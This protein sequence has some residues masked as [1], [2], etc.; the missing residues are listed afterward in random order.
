M[1]QN[2]LSLLLV[3]FSIGAMAQTQ[4]LRGT[5]TDAIS[6]Q[7]LP[8][9]VVVVLSHDPVKSTATDD[10]GRFTIPDISI[11]RHHIRITMMGYEEVDLSNVLVTSGKEVVLQITMQESI[12][13]ASEVTV[14]AQKDKSQAVN[15]MAGVSTRSF[16]V[17]ETQKFAAAVN[18][19][20]RM[21]MSFAGV[22]GG[23]DGNNLISIRGN[24]PNG[25]LWRMQ[26]VDIPNPNHFAS[27]ASSGGGISIISAQLLDNSDF[28]TG[29]FSA[30]YGNALSGV[31]DLKLRHGNNQKRE[32]TL[33]AGFLGLDAAIEGPMAKGG[34]YLVNYRYSTLNLLGKMGVPIGDELTNFQ[35]LSYVIFLPTKG[36]S[37]FEWYGFSGW[38][39]SLSQPEMDSSLWVADWNR[40]D[41]Q[42]KSNTSAHG[43]KHVLAINAKAY[44]QTTLQFSQTLNG[45]KQSRLNDD[46]RL[47]HNYTDSDRNNRINLSSVLN[48]KWN[49]KH[50]GRFGVYANSYAFRFKQ[51]HLDTL[52]QVLK[53]SLDAHGQTYTIQAFAQMKYRINKSFSLLYG[54]HALALTLNKTYSLEPRLALQAKCNDRTTYSLGYGM[55]SQMQP[56]GMYFAKDQNSKEQPNRNLDFSRAHHLVVGMDRLL[57]PYLHLKLETY[58]QHLFDVPVAIDP[59]NPLAAFNVVEN[60]ITE[61]MKNDGIGRNYGVELTFEQYTRNN[62]YF[63]LSASLYDSRYKANDG[64]WRNTRFNAN[65]SATFTAGKE[66]N[67]NKNSKRRVIGLNLRVLYNDGMRTTP[68]DYEAS[69]Q[70]GTTVYKEE[71]LYTTK[72][73]EYFRMDLRL[74]VRRDYH[75]VTTTLALDIQNATNHRN[76]QGEYYDPTANQVLTAYQVPFIPVLSY[77]IQF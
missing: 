35:D 53:Q 4:V 24:A 50:S 74:S 30:E 72:V 59:K 41:S 20:S 2:F 76:V 68:I 69:Q 32:V 9:A 54:V 16:S 10:L 5:V 75:K 22:V 45:Y 39:S 27:A 14:T 31:F 48:Y 63:L 25:L 26:G 8:G 55:H 64:T 18:D 66:M 44:L 51:E 61:P 62:F 56:L 34:S 37:S 19:P 7:P 12:A 3:F 33:Q 71:L 21:A 46:L 52:E 42:F 65:R 70:Q 11:G 77:K 49:A 36:K 58:Y 57:N 13:M 73:K 29:A 17:E 6:Q 60:Y 15:S 38:S 47:I 67:W 40:Y 1:R 28:S 43:L 23:S